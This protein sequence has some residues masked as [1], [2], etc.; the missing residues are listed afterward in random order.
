MGKDRHFAVYFLKRTLLALCHRPGHSTS[1]LTKSCQDLYHP[2]PGLLGLAS[3]SLQKEIQFFKGRF[4]HLLS[5]GPIPI[6]GQ[7]Q[8]IIR[9]D[10]IVLAEF[11]QIGNR[12]R[13]A[14]CLIA[15]NLYLM[16]SDGRRQFPLAL[17]VVDANINHALYHHIISPL[18]LT[19]YSKY[20]I[21][22]PV[23]NIFAINSG[24]SKKM[25]DKFAFCTSCF[26]ATERGAKTC[27]NCGVKLSK[28]RKPLYKKWWFW[29]L[30][31]LVAG[32]IIGV[33]TGVVPVRFSACIPA[34]DPTSN[35]PDASTGQDPL[36]S[37]YEAAL[38]TAQFYSELMH[39]SKQRIYERLTS[40][41]GGN[42]SPDAAQY[43]VD[44]LIADYRA[45]ALAK[46]KNYRKK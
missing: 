3:S 45:N 12:W 13:I 14:S 28:S 29:A 26:H 24:W 33:K 1:P 6:S 19:A 31:F 27:P 34:E 23:Y 41:C 10:M 2:A 44:H 46:A 5:P 38:K 8:Y 43:A 25:T 22:M 37:E 15:C 36:S 32:G 35:N 7:P 42:F 18:L 16:V 11:Y 9:T 21:I 30:L 17:I 39:M 20:V 40:E 4:S